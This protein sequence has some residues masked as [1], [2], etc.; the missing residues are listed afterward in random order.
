MIPKKDWVQMTAGNLIKEL[1]KVRPD[2]PVV[3][4][5]DAEGNLFSPLCEVT[6]DRYEAE[7]TWYGERTSQGDKVLILWPTN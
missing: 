4:S 7:T 6:E 5:K 2:T 3:M 1:L